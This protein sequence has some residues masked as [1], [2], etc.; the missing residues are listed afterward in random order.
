MLVFMEKISLIIFLTFGIILN[1]TYAE[2]ISRDTLDNKGLSGVDTLSST[3]F[4]ST[5]TN[6]SLTNKKAVVQNKFI[7]QSGIADSSSYTTRIRRSFYSKEDYRNFSDILN[8]VPFSF[9]QD[10]GSIGQPNEQMFYGLG[11]GNITYMSDGI[12]L[13]NRWQNSFDLNKLNNEIIDSVEISTLPKGFIY[14][15]Y[16][17]QVA[18]MFTNRAKYSLRPITQLKFYQASYDEGMVDV[19]FNLPVTNKFSVMLN[20]SNTAIDSRFSNS[21]YES[22][23]INTQLLYQIN[24]KINIKASYFFS[25]DTLALFGG[26]DTNKMLDDNFSTVLYGVDGTNSSRYQLTYNNSGNVKALFKLFPNL[27]SD[28]TIYFNSTSQKFIQ[29]IDQSFQNIPTI[30]HSN[31]YYTFGL[32]FRN[33]YSQKELSADIIANYETTN[34]NGNL[35]SKNQNQNIFSVSGNIKFPIISSEYFQPSVFGKI[36][37]DDGDILIGYGAD[38]TGLIFNRISYYAGVSNFQ[39][40]ASM[41]EREIYSYP[42]NTKCNPSENQ[43]LEIGVRLNYDW[44]NG[45]I[46]YFNLSSNNMYVPRIEN[47]GDTLLVNETSNYILNDIKNSGININIILDMW[48]FTVTNNL[49]Y[50]FSSREERVYASPDYTWAGKVYYNDVLFNNNLKLKTGMNFRFAGGQLPFVYDYEKSLQVTETLTPYVTFNSIPPSLQLDLFL[51]GT[52][53]ESATLFVTL[54]NIL[55]TKYY[56]VPYY[57][58]QSITLRFGVSWL[59]YD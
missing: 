17:N 54:E 35:F 45:K 40:Q 58:K 15:P 20:V 49:S 6:D 53:Q 7:Y 50:Y 39:K 37:S 10:L 42:N 55:D 57:F 23:K 56:I 16:N 46:S 5:T 27:K 8:Y 11:F 48:R 36:S 13:N 2:V 32:Y 12:Y 25:Y 14:S 41:L 43:T 19:L 22:W 59:L 47:N 31:F 18:I 29:N 28:F 9:S 44:I 33:T 3:V 38:I 24:D 4:D 51:A 30:N 34:V 21:D 1:H 26:L 52:I